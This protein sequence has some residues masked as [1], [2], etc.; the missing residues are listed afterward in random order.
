MFKTALKSH[1][2]L[3]PQSTLIAPFN[4]HIYQMKF[5][6]PWS[7]NWLHKE[8]CILTVVILKSQRFLKVAG[9]GKP[10]KLHED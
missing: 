7:I 8:Q 6:N 4:F 5:I 2:N 10:Q 9:A 3:K 1:K